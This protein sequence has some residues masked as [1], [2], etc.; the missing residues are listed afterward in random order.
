[1][2]TKTFQVKASAIVW[3]NGNQ[4]KWKEP[5]ENVHSEH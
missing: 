3:Q 1:M 2:F 5:S 4:T